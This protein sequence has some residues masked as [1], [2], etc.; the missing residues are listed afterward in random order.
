[1]V[2]PDAGAFV[3]IVLQ[4]NFRELARIPRQVWRNPPAPPPFR[5][6]TVDKL[7]ATRMQS[8][9]IIEAQRGHPTFVKSIRDLRIKAPIFE[10]LARNS[11]DDTIAIEIGVAGVQ[12]A[13][14]VQ[15]FTK[16]RRLIL[17][18]H[19]FSLPGDK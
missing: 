18:K 17:A 15:I 11:V 2:R 5:I 10:Q 6:V 3:E 14:A 16:G 12:N 1:M 7:I 4:A 9:D 13:I 8:V 19:G